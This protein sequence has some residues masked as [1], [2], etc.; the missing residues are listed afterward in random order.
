[1]KFDLLATSTMSLEAVVSRELKNLG[2]EPENIRLGRTLFSGDL[3]DILRANLNLRSAGR[4]LLRLGH[5]DATDFD[6]LFDQTYALPWEEWLP[7]D[8]A[9]PVS[10]RSQGSQLSSVPACQKTVK[11]AIAQKL[12]D[13]HGVE[14]LPE[15]GPTYAVEVDLF[16]DVATITLDTTGSSSLHKRGYRKLVGTAPL[17]ENLAAALVLLSFYE[18]ECPLIDP[19][20]GSGTIPIEAVLI[21]RNIPPGLSRAFAA[22]SWTQFSSDPQI[23]RDVRE[24]GR[25]GILP[26]LETRVIGYDI[27]PQMIALARR[28]AQEAG[29]EDSIHFQERAFADLHSSREYGCIIT[30][31]P[32][33]ERIGAGISEGRKGRGRPTVQI[34]AELQ[35]LYE[36]FPEVLNR[37]PTWSHFILTG[38]LNFEQLIR[39]EASRRRKLYNARIECTYFQFHGPRAPRDGEAPQ[40]VAPVFAVPDEDTTTPRQVEEYSNRLKKRAHHLRRFPTRRGITCYQIYDRDVPEVPV[41]VERYEDR[42]LVMERERPHDRR[43]LEHERW[44]EKILQA[45]SDVLN[46]PRENIFFQPL[47][48]ETDRPKF[49]PF[50]AHEDDKT[51]LL[52]FFN[53]D[54]VGLPLEQR[55]LRQKLCQ[56]AE[57]KR[58]LGLGVGAGSAT[59]AAASGGAIET[60]SV[61]ISGVHLDWTIANLERNELH[62]DHHFFAEGLAGEFLG[63]HFQKADIYDLALLTP[64]SLCPSPARQHPAELARLTQEA[65]TLLRPLLSSQGVVYVVVNH[66]RFHFP[67][68]LAGYEVREMTTKLH[69]E[70]FRNT[71]IQ[72]VWRLAVAVEDGPEVALS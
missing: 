17:S 60:T 7:T 28:H 19:F 65:L 62:G 3:R 57:G 40:E 51:Y 67:E 20:C 52:D 54:C 12:L 26:P 68:E 11:K 8:A 10:G 56:E 50:E 34:E 16:K 36:T 6:A 70:D 66:R 41:V 4:V 22:E 21:A 33:G 43:L 71:R 44:L 48:D 47:R 72:R 39:Q 24:E 37:L 5:F 31:P 14:S 32:Y 58:F 2:Y 18:R 38:V 29:V 55:L 45:T 9:F 46:V 64:A 69:P 30:N 42:L 1:M 13:A 59:V 49:E 25:D 63:D 35:K 53:R 15:T 27:D 23:I 61:D